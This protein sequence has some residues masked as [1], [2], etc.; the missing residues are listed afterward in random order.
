MNSYIVIK[1]TPMSCNCAEEVVAPLNAVALEAC[2]SGYR[3]VRILGADV[4]YKIEQEEYERIK[5][6]LLAVS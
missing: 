3:Y 1:V 4:G 6:I 5:K 2:T